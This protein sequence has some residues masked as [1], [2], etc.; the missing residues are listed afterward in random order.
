LIVD[1]SITRGNESVEAEEET[2][3]YT[4]TAYVH[5]APSFPLGSMLSAVA[6]KNFSYVSAE[7]YKDSGFASSGSIGNGS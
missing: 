7:L 1:R 5:L 4:L 2:E 3:K 6:G